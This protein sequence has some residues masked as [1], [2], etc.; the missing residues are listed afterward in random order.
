MLPRSLHSSIFDLAKCHRP[1][2]I[3]LWDSNFFDI[4]S[5]AVM[6]RFLGSARRPHRI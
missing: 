4:T 5:A 3:R 1:S 2:S 6:R